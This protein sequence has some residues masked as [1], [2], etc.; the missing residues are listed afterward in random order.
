M[1]AKLD[2]NGMHGL[3]LSACSC[4]QFVVTSTFFLQW[5]GK[6]NLME[7]HCGVAPI[8]VEIKKIRGG[9]TANKAVNALALLPPP[10]SRK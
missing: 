1:K 2:R 6:I 8:V 9:G 5:K 3:I 4:K 10:P 7:T